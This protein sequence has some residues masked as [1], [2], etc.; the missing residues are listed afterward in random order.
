VRIHVD[1]SVLVD[2]L[3]GPSPSP[4]PIENQLR[5]GNRLSIS[6]LVLFEWLRGPRTDA[7]RALRVTLF[8][9]HAL[10]VFGVD[11]AIRAATLYRGLRR[12]RQREVDIAIAACAIEHDAALWTLNPQDF[13]DIPGLV[14]HS[15]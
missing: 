8:P 1:T 11:E 3:T 9:D 10:V 12:A 7:E 6:T 14:L 15:T 5:R 13:K 2:T 4:D